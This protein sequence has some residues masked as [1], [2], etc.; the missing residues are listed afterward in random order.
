MSGLKIFRQRPLPQEQPDNV[1]KTMQKQSLRMIWRFGEI[2][3]MSLLRILNVV[4]TTTRII[5][6]RI[7]V[8]HP[9]MRSLVLRW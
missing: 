2:M 4:T 6:Q 7:L 3:T 8:K 5:V 1:L 9:I